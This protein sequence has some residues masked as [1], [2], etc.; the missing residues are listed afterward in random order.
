MLYKK[1]F[2]LKETELLEEYYSNFTKIIIV[3]LLKLLN[4]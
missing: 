4:I 1:G 2:K 3:L